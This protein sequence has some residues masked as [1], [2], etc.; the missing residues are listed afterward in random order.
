MGAIPKRAQVILDFWFGTPGSPEHAGPRGIWFKKD[1]KFDSEIRTKH[2]ADYE[3]ARDGRY[4]SW[5]SAAPS[6]L[7]LVVA[8]DQ[9]PRNLFRGDP[10]AFATDKQ[11]LQIAQDAIEKGFDA[12]VMPHQRIFYYLP[13]EHSED[14]S[15]Q[16]RCL[17]L[18]DAMPDFDLKSGYYD[19][20]LRHHKII[21]RFGRFPHRN[22]TLD[23]ES[24]PEEREYLAQPG[25]GF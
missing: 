23:R 18:I 20:A 19:Y 5:R 12:K 7:A 4:D 13:F 8:L 25:A 6:S 9:F 14:I 21:E 22:E 10:R 3:A 1:E 11:A 17:T 15:M 2:F 24:T 16:E